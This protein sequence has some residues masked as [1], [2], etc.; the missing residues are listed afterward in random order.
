MQFQLLAPYELKQLAGIL[1]N[2]LQIVLVKNLA[3]DRT[4]TRL[5]TALIKNIAI[6]NEEEVEGKEIPF[7][8]QGLVFEKFQ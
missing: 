5:A 7:T 8:Q 2:L 3:A 4:I 6:L 1:K